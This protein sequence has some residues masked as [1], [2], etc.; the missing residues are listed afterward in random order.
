MALV[1]PVALEGL[2]LDGLATVPFRPRIEFRTFLITQP[3]G[4][5]SRVSQRFIEIVE[6]QCGETMKSTVPVVRA[7]PSDPLF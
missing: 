1:N 3:S 4:N 7:A 2:D 6:R 5:L